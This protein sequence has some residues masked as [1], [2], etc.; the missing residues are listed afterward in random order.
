MQTR[1]LAFL[2]FATLLSCTKSDTSKEEPQAAEFTIS[3][4][5]DYTI[6]A[7]GDL[8]FEFEIENTPNKNQIVTVEVKG[9]PKN[10]DYEIVSKS[11]QTPFFCKV[12]MTATYAEKGTYPITVDVLNKWGAKKTATFN[13]KVIEARNCAARL[14]GLYGSDSFR[15]DETRT[16][17]LL[18]RDKANNL[19]IKLDLNCET[20]NIIVGGNHFVS[21]VGRY[22]YEGTGTFT[23]YNEISVSYIK[24]TIK[25][26]GTFPYT[27]V[28]T[29]D[30]VNS[31]FKR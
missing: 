10:I 18:L 21:G 5:R 7:D 25:Y 27:E 11:F 16:N 4:I 29:Y 2:F 14:E 20:K 15:I 17:G 28:K 1:I 26:V 3:N 9:L 19:D 13:L 8:N 6:R 23:P 24:E 22:N 12:E 31:T 30:T